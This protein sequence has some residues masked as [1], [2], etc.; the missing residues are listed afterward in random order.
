MQAGLQRRSKEDGDL[1]PDFLNFLS[2]ADE[3]LIRISAQ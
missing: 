3:G 1:L 2:I